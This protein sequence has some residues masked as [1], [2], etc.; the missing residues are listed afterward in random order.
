[1]SDIVLPAG[2]IKWSE[3]DPRIGKPFHRTATATV[4]GSD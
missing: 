3:T 2:F 1:M 4:R